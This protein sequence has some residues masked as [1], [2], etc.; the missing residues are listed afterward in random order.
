[1]IEKGVKWDKG[2]VQ[3]EMELEL[4][5]SQQGS[6]HEVSVSTE[7]VEEL[8]RIVTVHSSLRVTNIKSAL[9][10]SRD[11]EIHQNSH[12][13]TIS[14]IQNVVHHITSFGINICPTHY[15]RDNCQNIQSDTL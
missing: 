9:I 3:T 15:P 5:Q 7:G 12:S 1:M 11:K 10:E 4:E 6:S 2:I 13:D 14:N 8:K